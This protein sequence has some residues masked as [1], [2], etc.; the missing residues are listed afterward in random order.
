MHIKEVSLLM[1]QKIKEY[2]IAKDFKWR[3]KTEQKKFYNYWHRSDNIL[4]LPS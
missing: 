4:Y 3:S 2:R 1:K